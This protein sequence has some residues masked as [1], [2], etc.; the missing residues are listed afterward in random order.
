MKEV[1]RRLRITSSKDEYFEEAVEDAAKG[2]ALSG[3]NYQKTKQELLKFKDLDPIEEINKEKVN[4]RPKK[5]VEA[6]FIT[7][8]DPRML[9]PRQLISRNFHHI[10]SNPVLAELFPRENLKGACRRGKNL[11]ELLSPTVQ[12]APEDG[13]APGDDNDDDVGGAA[14]GGQRWNGSY[15]CNRYNSGRSCDVCSYMVET[16]TVT[17]YYFKRKFAICGRNI[18]LPASQK[19]KLTWFVYCVNDTACQMLY[20]GSTVDPCS[21]WAQTKKAC[22]DR[23]NT[24]TGLYKHFAEGCPTHLETEDVSHLTYTLLEHMDTSEEKLQRVGHGGGVSCRCKECE[25][26][27]N[28]EDKWMCRLGTLN[29]NRFG[30][31]SRDEIVSRARVNVRLNRDGGV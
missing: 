31:N 6:F 11:S 21:R 23:N 19:K 13:T 9:H 3:Y 10:Q 8:Y 27:K 16:S 4:K 14:G 18:H 5:G 17:S 25:K 29:T 15:H 20:V 22:L 7:D 1:G 24:N 30:L 26:L 2:F 28:M 12:E